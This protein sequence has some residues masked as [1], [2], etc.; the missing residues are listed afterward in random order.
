MEPFRLKNVT[1]RRVLQ[2]L[3]LLSIAANA[4]T[5]SED[6]A[7]HSLYYAYGAYCQMG[8]LENWGCKWCSE[9]N[10][11]ISSHGAG[12]VNI[13]ELQAF[14]GYDPDDNQIV[15]SFRGTYCYDAKICFQDWIDDLGI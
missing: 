14:I 8:D 5:Y 6:N 4:N 1:F 11:D 7:L 2:A 3:F 13:D 15:L 12:V 9:S 10:L